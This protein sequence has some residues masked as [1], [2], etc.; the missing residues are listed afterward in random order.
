MK[1]FALGILAGLI[2]FVGFNNRSAVVS[3]GSII[4]KKTGSAFNNAFAPKYQ[5]AQVQ[6][7][8]PKP[9]EVK[10]AKIAQTVKKVTQKGCLSSN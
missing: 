8:E 10:T 7:S 6:V 4:I 9:V 3:V 2:L 5:N 1:N